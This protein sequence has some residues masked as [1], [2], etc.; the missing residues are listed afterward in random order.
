MEIYAVKTPSKDSPDIYKEVLSQI[1]QEKQ[2]SFSKFKNFDDVKLRLFSELLTK[3]ILSLALNVSIKEIKCSLNRYGKPYL[4][5][6]K[7][8]HFNVSHSGKWVVIAVDNSE[9]GIDVEL[10]QPIDYSIAKR[11]FTDAEFHALERK[12]GQEKLAYFYDLWTLKES[13]IKAEGKGLSI[14]LNSFAI[15]KNEASITLERSNSKAEYYFR[16]YFIDY[17]YAL[18]VCAQNNFFP[19]EV[20]IIQYQNLI[21]EYLDRIKQV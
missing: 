20:H 1:D 12:R 3:T 10:I 6:R 15:I 9:I 21:N 19:G 11:F 4:E 17:K 14:P 8:L 7:D 13:F 16:Q 5:F 18:S 2:D